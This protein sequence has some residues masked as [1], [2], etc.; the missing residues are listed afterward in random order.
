[1]IFIS[2]WLVLNNLWVSR[3]ASVKF[4]PKRATRQRNPALE[5][6]GNSPPALSLSPATI[7]VIR[8]SDSLQVQDTAHSYSSG[9]DNNPDHMP[10]VFD[11]LH[12]TIDRLRVSRPAHNTCLS[13]ERLDFVTAVTEARS[14]TPSPPDSPAR[15]LAY[16]ELP[17]GAPVVLGSSNSALIFPPLISRG[18]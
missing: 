6:P 11:V 17:N 5:M 7:S 4:K 1:M 16:S 2:L 10:R 13:A 14:K 15:A 18:V 9:G 8:T 3:I 12:Q